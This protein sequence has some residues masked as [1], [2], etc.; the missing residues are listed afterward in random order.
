MLISIIE[1]FCTMSVGNACMSVC[2]FYTSLQRQR[3]MAITMSR[4]PVIGHQ[5]AGGRSVEACSGCAADAGD[6]QRVADRFVAMTACPCL[7]AARSG[8]WAAEKYEQAVALPVRDDRR[9]AATAV[10]IPLDVAVAVVVIVVA[11]CGCMTSSGAS[12]A[13]SKLATIS[14]TTMTD[15]GI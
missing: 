13:M 3:H 8:R 6:G 12:M 10:A 4:G 1:Y 5:A 9:N 7:S 2:L 15:F 14:V 11:G